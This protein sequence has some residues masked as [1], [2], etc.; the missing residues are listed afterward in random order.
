MRTWL[1]QLNDFVLVLIHELLA[2][3][4]LQALTRSL[5]ATD[6][7]GRRSSHGFGFDL[8]VCFRHRGADSQQTSLSR[9][10]AL[11]RA[12]MLDWENPWP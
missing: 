2:C 8:F 11:H 1:V 12:K 3:E 10:Q 4:R 7:N 9:H 5:E 6:D